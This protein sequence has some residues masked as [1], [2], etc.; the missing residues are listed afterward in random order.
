MDRLRSRQA[1]S[2]TGVRD[3][4]E[5][6]AA[7]SIHH[8]SSVSP[9]ERE[10]V[11]ESA[12]RIFVQDGRPVAYAFSS[13]DV[14]GRGELESIYVSPALRGRGLGRELALLQLAWLRARS[15][16][17]IRVSVAAGNEAALPFYRSLGFFPRATVLWL[18]EGGGHSPAA[19]EHQI[20][21]L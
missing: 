14:H 18:A 7:C 2:A 10:P 8:A 1:A 12:D 9:K 11:E 17:P 20:L 21:T 13:V 19:P 6:A 15:A 4:I 16:W 3:D 5:G